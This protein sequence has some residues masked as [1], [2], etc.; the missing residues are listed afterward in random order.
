MT[1]RRGLRA[2]NYTVRFGDVDMTSLLD[3]A[4]TTPALDWAISHG[5]HCH[6]RID[7]GSSDFLQWAHCWDCG[8]GGEDKR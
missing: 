6:H 1:D 4:L 7:V 5:K 8:K 3:D 2:P